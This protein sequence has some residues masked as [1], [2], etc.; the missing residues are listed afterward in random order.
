M[1]P[2]SY[3]RKVL[4]VFAYSAMSSVRQLDTGKSQ[5]KDKKLNSG[6]TNGVGKTDRDRKRFEGSAACS[7]YSAKAP[8]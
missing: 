2:G 7:T 8:Y 5:T 4:V 1:I 3:D 6:S